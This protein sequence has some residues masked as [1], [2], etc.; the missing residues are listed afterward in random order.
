M[1]F[2]IV[3]VDVRHVRPSICYMRSSLPAGLLAREGKKVSF[4][5]S[6]KVPDAPRLHCPACGWV[7]LLIDV[8]IRQADVLREALHR[9]SPPKPSAVSSPCSYLSDKVR[10]ANLHDLPVC[11]LQACGL[12]AFRVGGQPAHKKTCWDRS[13]TA[14][15]GVQ[16]CTIGS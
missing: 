6:L 4:R 16:L 5:Q 11:S 13:C 12:S 8:W 3:T 14:P 15:A 7:P 2:S 10:S 1:A 9:G